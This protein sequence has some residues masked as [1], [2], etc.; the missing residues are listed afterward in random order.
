M[1][2]GFGAEFRRE[3]FEITAGEPA[4]YEVGPFADLASARTVPGRLAASGGSWSRN[5]SAVYVDVD[6]EVTER[7]NIDLAGR[8]ED[9]STFGSTT[10]GKLSTRFTVTDWLNLRCGGEHR[11]PC[12]DAGPGEPREHESVSRRAHRYGAHSRPAATD[13]RG[14]RALRR[15]RAEARDLA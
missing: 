7:W 13:Q 2:V 12:A 1:N 3:E 8:F 15:N 9:Y 6:A 5:D 11:F 14:G 10:N 4:S